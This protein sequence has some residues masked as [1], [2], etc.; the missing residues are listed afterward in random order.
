MS[1]ATAHAGGSMASVD[2]EVRASAR[3][4]SGN[5]LLAGAVKGV[6]DEPARLIAP[7]VIGLGLASGV[8]G[9]SAPLV[10]L[11]GL[12]VAVGWAQYGSG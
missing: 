7:A 1:G 10:G 6:V 11:V 12:S 3:R 9:L 2:A 5:R 8:L 4:R